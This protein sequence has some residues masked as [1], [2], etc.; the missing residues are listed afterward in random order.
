MREMRRK[1]REIRDP[2]RMNEIIR[3]CFCCRLGFQDGEDVYIVPLNFG[4]EEQEGRRVFYF[5]GA[6]EGRKIDLV[7]SKGR[8]G[9]ELDRGYELKEGELPCQY[10]ARFQSV[11]GWGRVSMIEEEKEKQHALRML[12]DHYTGRKN[13]KF[14]ENMMKQMGIFKLEVEEISCKEH[15]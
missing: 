8:A 6:L 4:F 14:P 9:F 2:A 15:E 10:S 11:V 1:D 5:H 3:S 12:M 7:R 13:W